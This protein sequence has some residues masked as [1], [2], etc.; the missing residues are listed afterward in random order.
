MSISLPHSCRVYHNSVERFISHI[1]KAL[2]KLFRTRCKDWLKRQVR[3]L[4]LPTPRYVYF[5]LSPHLDICNKLL[6]LV[7]VKDSPLFAINI[8]LL[9]KFL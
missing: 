1:Q 5:L 7:P 3:P 6:F 2:N 9:F 8:D 4:M